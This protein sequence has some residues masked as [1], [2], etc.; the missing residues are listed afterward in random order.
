MKQTINIDP[1]LKFKKLEDVYNIP[2]IVRVNKFNEE[3]LDNFDHDM[4]EAQNT[5][6]PVIPIIIDSYGGEV[7]GLFGMMSI[8]ENCSVPVAT[9][10]TSKIMSAGAALFCYGTEGYRYLD[11]HATVM[12]HDVACMNWGKIEEIKSQTNQA[13]HLNKTLFTRIA[14]NVGKPDDYFIKIIREEHKHV[15]WYLTAKD[16]K[17]HNIAN[18]LR[19]P[20]FTINIS[21]N[22]EFK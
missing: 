12:I 21:L 1:K 16:A 17:K 19:I 15:D 18:H 2:R 22:V 14:R 20:E 11:P 5:G 6:Q 10:A 8:I 3:A 7:Y 9:I 4:R 13:E